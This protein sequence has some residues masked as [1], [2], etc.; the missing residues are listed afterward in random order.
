[1]FEHYIHTYIHLYTHAGV[2]RATPL[3]LVLVCVELSDILFA[4]DSI[5]AIFGVTEDPFIIFTS[6][7]FAILG[8]RCVKMH[9]DSPPPP[10]R[11]VMCG[12]VLHVCECSL[13]WIVCTLVESLHGPE[14][15]NLLMH[16]H[17][18]VYTY[19]YIYAHTHTRSN[20]IHT[21]KPHAHTCTRKPPIH[22]LVHIRTPSMCRA[23]F[24]LVP[25]YVESDG[26]L[27]LS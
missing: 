20:T 25:G 3:L 1:M 16:L 12:C 10:Q 15:C 4:V 6:N 19:I 21:H 14:P 7:I 8:L 2:K 13:F 26:E 18:R 22:T 5:P 9:V 23:L 24:Q 27:A 11:F 17:M